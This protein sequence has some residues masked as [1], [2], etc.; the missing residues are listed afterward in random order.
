MSLTARERR[1]L[2]DLERQFAPRRRRPART[3]AMLTASWLVCGLLFAALLT[4]DWIPAA[5]AGALALCVV[6]WQL[7]QA[8]P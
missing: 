5:V 2:A 4:D 1:V 7:I 8:R 6:T 3:P